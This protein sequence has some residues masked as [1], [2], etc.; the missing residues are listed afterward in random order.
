[1]KIVAADFIRSCLEKE[2]FPHHDL[3]ELAFV[4][5]S[6]V[7]KSSLIN[8]LLSRKRLA[9]VSGTPGK[10]RI[11]N[12]FRVRTADP[13][14][15]SFYLVDLPGYGYARVSKSVRAQ[16][17]PM[18]EGYL[19]GRSC[20]RAILLLVDARGLE[21]HDWATFEWLSE[22]GQPLIVVATKVDKLTHGE[23][24]NRLAAIAETLGPPGTCPPIPY[25][26]LTHEG[27][28][29]LWRAIRDVLS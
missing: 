11:L 13:R 9:K 23:R 15:P 16:W 19:T 14:L 21:R 4:G 27:R 2:Q 7:G 26:S 18:I 3:P 8:S 6:N 1:M 28:D 25:S 12:F 29:E 24:R 22:A 5:R 20:L 17:G 10:T